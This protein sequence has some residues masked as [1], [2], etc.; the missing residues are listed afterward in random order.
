MKEK[1]ERTELGRR[2]EPVEETGENL[3]PGS[4]P[5][6]SSDPYKNNLI[7]QSWKQI[8]NKYLNKLLE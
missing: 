3:E 2:G 7:V 5:N 4:G 1:E 6:C 8:F